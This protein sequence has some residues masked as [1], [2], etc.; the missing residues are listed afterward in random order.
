V[1]VAFKFNGKNPEAQAAVDAFTSQFKMNISGQTRDAINAIIHRA[2]DQGRPP[3]EIAGEIRKALTAGQGRGLV[4]TIAGL[5]RR[6]AIAVDNFRGRLVQSGLKQKTIDKRVKRYAEKKLRER[7]HAIARTE[8]MGALNLG[9]RNAWEQAIK[10]KGLNRALGMKEYI[11]T[12]DDRL[13]PICAPLDGERIPLDETF[14]TGVE[15]PP[16]HVMCRC[17]MG[18]TYGEGRQ[19]GIGFRLQPFKS[20][21]AKAG[22]PISLI[23]GTNPGGAAFGADW[24]IPE[25]VGYTRRT[26][27]EAKIAKL[28]SKYNVRLRELPQRHGDKNYQFWFKKTNSKLTVPEWDVLERRIETMLDEALAGMEHM[29]IAGNNLELGLNG[30]PRKV[31]LTFFNDKSTMNWGQ[32]WTSGSRI[33]LNLSCPDM[34]TPEKWLKALRREAKVA[35]GAKGAAKIPFHPTSSGEIGTLMVHEF[36]HLEH[37]TKGVNALTGMYK[38]DFHGYKVFA[39]IQSLIPEGLLKHNARTV[40]GRVSKYAKKNGAEFV[41]ETWTGLIQGQKFDDEVMKLYAW[42]GG[43]E[44]KFPKKIFGAVDDAV[45][46]AA[47]KPVVPGVKKGKSLLPTGAT[48]K[49]IPA[50]PAGEKIR[51]VLALRKAGKTYTQIDEIVYGKAGTN[52]SK[53]F[54]VVKKHG[55][56]IVDAVE[57]IPK[58]HAWP[59]QEP[60]TPPTPTP[61]VV[62]PPAATPPAP[63]LPK[64]IPKGAK[65]NPIPPGPKGDVIRTTLKLRKE[66]K[67]YSEIDHLLFGKPAKNSGSRSFQVMKKH[68]LHALDDVTPPAVTP[69]IEPPPPPAP[70]PPA[71]T[72]APPPPAKVIDEIVLQLWTQDETIE[73][74]ALETGLTQHEVGALLVKHGKLPKSFLPPAPGPLAD[75]TIPP[76]FKPGAPIPAGP[77][78]DVIKRVLALRKEGKTYSEIDAIVFNAHGSHGSKSHKLVKKYGP[79]KIK[80][81]EPV[82]PKYVPPEDIFAVPT[83]FTRPLS[84]F[85]PTDGVYYPFTPAGQ[86]SKYRTQSEKFMNRLRA[87]DHHAYSVL[88]NYKTTGYAQMNAGLRHYAHNSWKTVDGVKK[89]IEPMDRAVRGGVLNQQTTLWR[90]GSPFDTLKVGE[91]FSDK[92]YLSTSFARDRAESFARGNTIVKIKA[93]RG[94]RGAT[95]SNAHTGELEW[96]LPRDAELRIVKITTEQKRYG[97]TWTIYECELVNPAGAAI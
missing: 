75:P 43:P 85:V 14:S 51:E 49:P 95:A 73:A 5:N 17:T 38:H 23:G 12:P 46:K 83:E 25:A 7:A 45:K 81:P 13:C 20:G 54:S 21:P 52:G 32:A 9:S 2:I 1:P 50:G 97:G 67:S 69:P 26:E 37:L 47:I 93:P 8:T 66:G 41:A 90:G 78:G 77:K 96:I 28:A 68:G 36:G 91:T 29:T 82:G 35:P 62:T 71:P 86:V 70:K 6:Q 34:D 15:Y 89:V 44:V 3:R 11:V 58:K 40:A 63:T 72:P 48:D 79:Q 84:E 19:T 30:L 64:W 16:S 39:H 92:A 56:G 4:R 74:I 42:L 59:V 24:K 76:G 27:I 61:P 65:K 94:T 60:W 31:D 87:L 88:R 53:S 57:E 80:A 10:E 33:N 18:V 55:K 22:D